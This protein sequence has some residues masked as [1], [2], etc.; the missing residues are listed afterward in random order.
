[1]RMTMQPKSPIG[2]R[3]VAALT[4]YLRSLDMPPGAAS[5]RGDAVARGEKIFAGRGCTTCHPPPLYSNSH[6]YD[7]GLNDGD[8]G[9][10]L[11]NPPSL[12][13]LIHKAPYL[14][15][16]RAK[17]VDEVVEKYQ[18]RLR[19]PLSDD[20]AHDLVAFLKSL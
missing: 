8:G 1:M 16:G 11:F 17:T 10:R 3:A 2:E 6:V 18:H 19:S 15:D 7:V 5:V 9:N 14:H 13:G 4:A 20:E 12:R